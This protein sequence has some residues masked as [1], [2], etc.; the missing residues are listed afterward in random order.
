MA[1]RLKLRIALGKHDHVKPLR[2][3]RVLATGPAPDVLTRDLIRAAFDVD[4]CVMPASHGS[5]VDY[6]DF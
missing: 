1:D 3:G 2:E 4:A 5:Y 6:V